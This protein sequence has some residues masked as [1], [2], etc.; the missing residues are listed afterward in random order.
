MFAAHLEADPRIRGDGPL[1]VIED[2]EPNF[3]QSHILEGFFRHEPGRFGAVTP[4]PNVFLTDDDAKERRITI[5]A[6]R[7]V[8]ECS[9]AD[10]TLGLSLMD[11]KT[12]AP[13][14]RGQNECFEI[15]S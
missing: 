5:S 14:R 12:G 11:G 10:E 7:S 3:A 1:I 4:I 2:L 13:C 6:P 15:S 8:C 9:G